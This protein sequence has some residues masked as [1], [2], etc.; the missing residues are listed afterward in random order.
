MEKE[1]SIIIVNWNS[2]FQLT[3]VLDSIKRNHHDLISS[4]IVVDNASADNSMGLINT[5]ES[6]PFDLKIVTN[7][8]NLG[9]AFACNQGARL[10]NSEYLL[11]LNPDTL[12]FE[13]SLTTVIDFLAAP[14]SADVGICGIQLVDEKGHVARTCARFPTLFR[15]LS[16]AFGV[17][18]IQRFGGTGVHMVDWDHL[19]TKMVDHVIGA[20]YFTRRSVFESLNGFDEKFFVYL[21]DVDFSL[22]AKQA[23]WKTV[24]L[25]DAQA[26]H[27][28]GGTSDKVK[29]MR[30]FYSVRSRIFYSFKH[31]SP[32][33][34]WLL[35][36]IVLFVEPLNRVILSLFKHSRMDAIDTWKG[37]SLLYRDLP[38][39]LYKRSN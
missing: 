18:R 19:S 35:L 5:S 17:N 33:K 34:A 36:F 8:V 32:W 31:F 12:L 24:Y 3:A 15:F 10:A 26:F 14:Q 30:L 7:K 28:G 6:C 21:E 23:G 25:K 2:A 1:I 11:F 27:L 13:N 4:V 16:Q 9:F 29:A 39:I 38:D 22:R 37:Y 20:F